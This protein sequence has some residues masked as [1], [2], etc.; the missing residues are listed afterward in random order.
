M[1]CLIVLTFL[2]AFNNKLHMAAYT[3]GLSNQHE[4]N[5]R[6]G[7]ATVNVVFKYL[8]RSLRLSLCV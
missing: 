2:M 4:A 8:S 1:F 6:D 7:G 3:V 5:I